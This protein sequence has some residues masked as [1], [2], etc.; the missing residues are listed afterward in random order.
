MKLRMPG[1]P[2]R[3]LIPSLL[4]TAQIRNPDYKLGRSHSVEGI[5]SNDSFCLRSH[6]SQ[7]VFIWASFFV[8]IATTYHMPTEFSPASFYLAQRG[9]QATP[10]H[11]A[12]TDPYEDPRHQMNFQIGEFQSKGH[13]LKATRFP[14]RSHNENHPKSACEI[15]TDPS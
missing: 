11:I 6:T 5:P 1:N 10:F 13:P 8:R 4:I 9:F 3:I 2:D 12:K 14:Q 7:I 15:Q